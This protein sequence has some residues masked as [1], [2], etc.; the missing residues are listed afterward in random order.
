MK[1][2]FLL[3]VLGLFY[4]TILSAQ[5]PNVLLIIA[6]DMGNDAIE[7]FGVDIPN[8]PNTPNLNA[9]KEEGITYR[10]A[11]AT[12]ICSPTRASIMSGKYGIKTGVMEVPGNLDLEH[13]SLFTYID[14][15]TNDAY[16]T[17][18]IGKWHISS[19][20]NP[21]HPFEHGLDHYE[22]V[23]AGGVQDYYDWQ[24]VENG[25]LYRWRNTL[26]LI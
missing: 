23:I 7:G 11:W 4:T 5:Q 13:E 14:R 18:V 3:L 16:S 20:I 24:K 22:G 10:N 25:R 2:Y 26:P 15:E 19:P 17:A 12:P 21:N 1:K 8:F 6:D 9:L